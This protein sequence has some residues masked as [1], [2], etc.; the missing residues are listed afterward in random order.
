MLHPK[1]TP[2]RRVLVL[3]LAAV[4]L[5]ALVSACGKKAEPKNA[6]DQLPGAGQGQVVATYKGGEISQGEFDKYTSFLT[7]TDPQTA[8]YLQIPQFKEPF[9]KQYVL[10]KVLSTRTTDTQKKS[11]DDEAAKF[12]TQV[13]DAIKQQPSLKDQLEQQKITVAEMKKFVKALASANQVVQAKQTEVS[14]AVKDTDL[15]AV[16]DKNPSDYNVATVRHILITTSDPQT[17]E[18]KR[19]DADALKL[20]KE[21]KDKLEKGGDWNEIAKQYSEDPGSKDNGGLYEKQVVKG[22]VTEFKNA[23]NTQPIGKIGDPVKV[24]YG[25][26]VIMVASRDV[27][28]FDKLS[29][30][31]KD[32]LKQEVVDE[33]IKTYLEGEQNSLDIKVTLP[34]EPS[35]SP[36]ASPT[37]SA[38]ASPSA[39]AS[40]TATTSK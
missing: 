3:A 5:A 12:E 10:Y 38:P 35:P 23:A 33:K 29:A 24:S 6:T 30:E 31:T 26:H 40:P 28:A 18:E 39:T 21:V 9:L 20:A 37:A 19:S 11:A 17:G 4:M 16:F 25:Y 2:I 8:M 22:W 13:N 32:E 27:A 1:R 7:V 15:K 36:S 34:A 14:G